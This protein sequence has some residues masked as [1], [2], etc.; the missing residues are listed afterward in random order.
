M[1]KTELDT[2]I[3]EERQD[4]PVNRERKTVNILENITS[5]TELKTRIG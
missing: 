2:L 4:M 1:T 5:V 3:A